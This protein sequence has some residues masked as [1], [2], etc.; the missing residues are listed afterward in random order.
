[1]QT[2]AEKNLFF[3]DSRTI[4]HSKASLVARAYDVPT[5]G[6]DVFLDDT[7]S[8]HAVAHQ[9]DN[10]ERQ[11][12]KHGI[13][14]AIGHPHDVTM[15]AL[16]RWTAAEKGFTLVPVST[17]IRMEEARPTASAALLPSGS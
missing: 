6:R 13:A 8:A 2:L 17:A 14:I 15:A 7:I 10:L 5:A 9:L 3:L 4:G 16:E 1:M 12:R 11:A